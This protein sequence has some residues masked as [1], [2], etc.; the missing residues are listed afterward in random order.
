MKRIIIALSLVSVSALAGAA[1][2]PF[3][4]QDSVDDA[5]ALWQAM[6]NEG[7]VG[8]NAVHSRPY[9]GVPPH[10]MVLDT[11]EKDI[12]V[13]GHTG[14]VIIKRNYGG[15]G[16]DVNKVAKDPKPWLKAVTVM[17]KRE[18]GYDADNQNWFWAKYKPNGS[19]HSNPKKMLLAG[20]VAKGKPAGCISCHRAAPG[21]DYLFNQ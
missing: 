14:H 6:T 7:L 17:F 15:K 13:N 19:L 1:G 16:V 8:D 20:R 11:I 4:G 21:G 12:T 10:G 3:G 5:K 9:K 18:N 2:M